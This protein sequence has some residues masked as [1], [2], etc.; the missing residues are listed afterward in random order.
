[1]VSRQ[2]R[3]EVSRAYYDALGDVEWDRL[4]RDPAARASL[5]V[6]RR[7]LARHVRPGHRVLEIGAGPGRFTPSSP[8]S[9]PPSSSPTS[10]RS[11]WSSTNDTCRAHRRR[12]RW[13]DGSSS[14]CATPRGSP[15]GS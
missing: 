5:E 15:T 2:E 10:R 6:H 13:N 8:H 1:M 12:T 7:F 3:A 9:A 11:S 14:T 4:V